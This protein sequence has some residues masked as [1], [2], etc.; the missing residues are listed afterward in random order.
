MTPEVT[1]KLEAF[2]QTLADGP[3]PPEKLAE[4]AEVS[5]EEATAF[6]E[7]VRP[8]AKGARKP[9]ASPRPAESSPASDVAPASV[10]VAQARTPAEL[11][12]E[13]AE[14]SGLTVDQI[15]ALARDIKGDTRI[16]LKHAVDAVDQV[17]NRKV[18]V[19]LVMSEYRGAMADKIVKLLGRT[20]PAIEFLND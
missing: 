11:L 16:R 4:L 1:Q 9:K 19:R 18:A 3:V 6:I 14:V 8:T 7:A 12:A 20:H 5:V 17:G 2:R 15:Y 10:P 13:L